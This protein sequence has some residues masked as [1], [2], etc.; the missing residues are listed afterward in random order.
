MLRFRPVRSTR[1]IIDLPV[2]ADALEQGQDFELV[3][4][5]PTAELYGFAVAKDNTAL[6]DA[7]NEAL[8]KIKQDGTLAKLYQKYFNIEPPCSVLEGTTESS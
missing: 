7:M 2:A 1:S 5:I 6:L 4:E 8:Q 3:E